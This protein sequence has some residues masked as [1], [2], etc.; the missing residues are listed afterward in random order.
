M[1]NWLRK[2]KIKVPYI[3][4]VNDN[5]CG[6][7]VLEMIYKFYGLKDVSQEVIF[8]KYKV[9]E[10]HGTGNFRLDTDSLVS[11][12]LG[13]G[14]LSFW[15]KVDF[16]NEQS[17]ADLLRTLVISKKIPLIVCQK[18]TD[19]KQHEGLGHFRVVVGI[20]NDTVYVHDPHPTFGG[21][22][23]EWNIQKFIEYWKPT[24]NNVTGG[25]FV[26]IKPL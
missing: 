7:A 25:V 12:A 22:F 9:L 4:Q 5:A 20:T 24:G 6:S 18:F 17:V 14:F 2:S 23:Q 11:D 15:A 1:S 19:E 26:V 3:K 13:R 10:P 8:E 16:N 21:A